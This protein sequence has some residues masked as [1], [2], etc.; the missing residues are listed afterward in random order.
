M[1]YINNRDDKIKNLHDIYNDAIPNIIEI[2]GDIQ[3]IARLEYIS[4][5]S[6]AN[7][8]KFMMYD[9]HYTILDHCVGVALILD[10]YTKENKQVIA[11]LL[12]GI[13]V[14]AFNESVKHMNE[15]FNEKNVYDIIVSSDKLFE[16]FLNNDVDI[17]D[18]CDYS[19]YPLAKAN[20][21]RMDADSIENVLRNSYISGNIDIKE[22]KKIY[23]DLT[24][25]KNEVGELEFAFD[26]YN[27]AEKFCKLSLD[28]ARKYRS[29]ELKLSVKIVATLL[30]LMIKREE[31]NIE[32]LYKYGDKA[33]YE[34]GV[35][36]SDKRIS[37]GW[38][39]LK[40][41]DKVYT[42]FNPVDDKFC[43]KAA[44]DVKYVDPL[45]KLK[46]GY[47]RVSSVSLEMKEEITQF[48]NS[49]TD[50]YMFADFVI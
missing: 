27:I 30:E 34:I 8:T 13:N 19:R 38:Q 24:I 33:I 1:D 35:N 23:E 29:Y 40:S 43:V 39:K 10:K 7:M 32:D 14:P 28:I 17:K 37:N 12:H 31:I 48:L 2:F 47:T 21:I 49:D 20:G 42:K 4:E 11:G 44:L 26:N 36:S 15:I 41:V 22:L 3:E 5:T 18:I 50:L 6:G 16:Y 46:G 45:V 25:T 9:N